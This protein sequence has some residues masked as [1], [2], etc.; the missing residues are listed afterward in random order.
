MIKKRKLNINDKNFIIRLFRSTDRN[1]L[2]LFFKQ[3]SD[4]MKKWFSPKLLNYEI[5]DVIRDGEEEILKRLVI[6]NNNKIVG[7]CVIVLGLRRWERFRYK[8]KFDASKICTIAPC[9]K[10]EF[11]NIGLG[12]EM[13]KYVIDISKFYNKSVI[14]LWGGVVLKNKR[15]IHFYKKLGFKINKKWLHPLAKVMSYDMYLRI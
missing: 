7:Y 4:E 2:E 5:E 15:A 13:M 9:I 14:F 10:D 11:Q 3:A 12:Y 8:G 6:F 1:E